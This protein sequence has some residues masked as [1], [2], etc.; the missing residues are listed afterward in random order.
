MNPTKPRVVIDSTD[1][2]RY[3]I[4]KALL[5]VLADWE[6]MADYMRKGGKTPPHEIRLFAKHYTKI[7]EIVRQQSD[8]KH[9]AADVRWKGHPLTR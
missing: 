1:L 5:S 6:E 8:Q 2:A 4:S 3:K 7:D 9:S